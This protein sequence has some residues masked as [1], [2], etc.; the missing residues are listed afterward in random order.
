MAG[1]QRKGKKYSKISYEVL[2]INKFRKESSFLI[3]SWIMGRKL[4][5]LL[6]NF[7]WNSPLLKQYFPIT[8]KKITFFKGR[9]KSFPKIKWSHS[10]KTSQNR[11]LTKIFREFLQC[12]DNNVS[13]SKMSYNR[14]EI[15]YTKMMSVIFILYGMETWILG[16]ISTFLLLSTNFE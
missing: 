2:I 9:I 8:E 16:G 4:L 13:Y 5:K 12:K 6:K 7:I 14:K 15:K 1:Y 3:W 11:K 10:I